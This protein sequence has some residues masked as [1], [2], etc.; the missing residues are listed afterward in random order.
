MGFCMIFD[1]VGFVL[2]ERRCE[3]WGCGDVGMWGG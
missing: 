1:G 2:R 3:R